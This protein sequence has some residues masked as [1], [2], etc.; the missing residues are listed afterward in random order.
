MQNT[1]YVTT[2]I[3]LPHELWRMLKEKA[4]NEHKSLSQLFR[5]GA[6]AILEGRTVK[7]F[8]VR[9]KDP[10]YEIVGKGQGTKDGAVKH[11]EDLYGKKDF[12]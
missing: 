8:T 10:F 12:C 4:L 7:S 9:E 2:N 3:R 11:D 1:E 5:E 6:E